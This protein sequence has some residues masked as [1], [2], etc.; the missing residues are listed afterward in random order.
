MS[1]VVVGEVEIIG[2]KEGQEGRGNAF[3]Y[4]QV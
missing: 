1:V 3:L 2:K 4:S